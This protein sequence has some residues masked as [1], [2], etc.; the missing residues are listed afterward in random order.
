MSTEATDSTPTND[1]DLATTLLELGHAADSGEIDREED[2]SAKLP[3]PAR[4]ATEKAKDE[5]KPEAQ[6]GDDPT[7][8]KAPQPGE[9]PGDEKKDEKAGTDAERAAKEEERKDRSWK[10]L[11]AEKATLRADKEALERQ[12]AEAA[13]PEVKP[14]RADE[15]RDERGYTAA[16]YDQAAK[17]FEAE[18][19]TAL[20]AQARTAA[21]ALRAKEG[22]A[23]QQRQQAEHRETWMKHANETVAAKAELQDLNTPLAKEVKAMLTAEPVFQILPDGFKK[24]VEICELRLAAAEVPSLKA[25]N[26]TLRKDLQEAQGKLA[27]GDGS[28]TRPTKEKSL[29]DLSLDAQEREI[30]RM[31]STFDEENAA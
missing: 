22:E 14:A 6:P 29:G 26:E 20:A 17:D 19:D 30:R 7:K 9:K 25:E 16:Q 12:R 4:P 28:V 27:I 11:E 21:E 8:A 23:T 2:I 10:A 18:G 31:A 1:A 3:A 13:K 5:T 24:A 15:T